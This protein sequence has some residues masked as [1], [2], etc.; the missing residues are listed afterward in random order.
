M[1]GSDVTF[2]TLA[3]TASARVLPHNLGAKNVDGLG[4]GGQL[5]SFFLDEGVDASGQLRNVGYG[6]L[7]NVLGR[8]GCDTGRWWGRVRLSRIAAEGFLIP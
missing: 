3:S 1:V 5:D 6:L 2:T 8:R 7:W 4:I